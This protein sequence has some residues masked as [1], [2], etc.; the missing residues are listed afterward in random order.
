MII[1]YMLDEKTGTPV[2]TQMVEKGYENTYLLTGGIEQ[3]LEEYAELVEGTDVPVPVKKI[4]ED[5]ELK[6]QQLRNSKM[7]HRHSEC[8]K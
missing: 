5:K 4:Q 7:R 6:K 2:A 8:K 1:V 3:F